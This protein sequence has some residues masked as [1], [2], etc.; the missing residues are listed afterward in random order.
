MVITNHHLGVF[1][2]TFDREHNICPECSCY[3]IPMDCGF[4]YCKYR[5]AGFKYDELTG[6]NTKFCSEW[7][8]CTKEDAYQR[9]GQARNGVA[10]WSR[11][12]IQAKEIAA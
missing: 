1:D 3:V 4:Y 10:D 5:F 2:L 9:F 7:K 12:I 11:L 8:T 6:K